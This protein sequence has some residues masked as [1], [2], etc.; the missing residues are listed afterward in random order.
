MKGATYPKDGWVRL[1]FP[2]GWPGDKKNAFT[3]QGLTSEEK[4]IQDYVKNLANFRKNSSAIKSGKM[5]QYVP[6]DGCYV[7]FRY[8]K[9]QIVMIVMNVGDKIQKIELSKYS[10]VT[11][12]FQKGKDV[13]TGSMMDQIFNVNPKSITILELQ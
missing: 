9:K 2:G 10:D 13:I 7:Y 4:E 6:K 12:G 1:D 3:Q 5:M 8:D 11:Q